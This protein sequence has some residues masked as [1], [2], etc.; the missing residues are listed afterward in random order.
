MKSVGSVRNQPITKSGESKWPSTGTFL[1][2][3]TD[4]SYK[5]P[6]F[7]RISPNPNPNPNYYNNALF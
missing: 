2:F 3:A 6:E 7:K 1:G 4:I 5:N